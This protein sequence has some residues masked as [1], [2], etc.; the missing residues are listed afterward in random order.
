MSIAQD[1]ATGVRNAF[2][3]EPSVDPDAVAGRLRKANRSLGRSLGRIEWVGSLERYIRRTAD[4][5][6]EGWTLDDVGP[7]TPPK[8]TWAGR[9]GRDHPRL[10]TLVSIEQELWEAERAAHSTARLSRARRLPVYLN[11]VEAPAWAAQAAQDALDAA[12]LAASR[13]TARKREFAAEKYWKWD[14]PNWGQARAA[15]SLPFLSQI[16]RCFADGLFA[17]ASFRR[18]TETRTILIARPG[19]RLRAGRLHASDLPAVVWP[20]GSERWYWDGIA[21]PERIAASRDQLTAELIARID[22]QELRRVTLE[23]VGWD[24]FIATA[25]AELR[26][27]DDYGKL[28]ATTIRIDGEHVHLVEVVNA[29]AEP[30]GSHRR[31]FLRV[32]PNTRTARAAVAWTFGFE[33]AD[34]YIVAAAS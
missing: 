13:P 16:A 10:G 17:A 24:R 19:L 5:V 12:A 1:V 8:R 34:D 28:W 14:D 7:L 33:N 15:M 25:D 21:V 30:D 22:N 20:D 29:T 6:L 23:R 4:L 31:Y 26:A 2:V 3:R 27:Q 11:A 9:G 32:P 18:G